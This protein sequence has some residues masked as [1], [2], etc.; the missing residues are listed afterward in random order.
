MHYIRLY[1]FFVGVH[2][3]TILARNTTAG[4]P[5]AT[6]GGENPYVMGDRSVGDGSPCRLHHEFLFFRLFCCDFYKV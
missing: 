5:E 3:G 1:I 4:V 6:Y 2:D